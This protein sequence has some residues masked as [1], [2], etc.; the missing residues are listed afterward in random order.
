ML[1]NQLSA[2]QRR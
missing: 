2:S 1:K